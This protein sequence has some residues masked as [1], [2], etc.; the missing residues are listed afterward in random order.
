MELIKECFEKHNNAFTKSLINANFSLDEAMKFLPE[1]ISSILES[2]NKTSVYQ[3]MKILMSNRPN[4]LL[5]KINVPII[6]RK[7]EMTQFQV[8]TGLQAIAPILLQT[9]SEAAYH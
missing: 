5:R 8:T 2:S 9:Y 6:A 3:T 7:S 1:A 4:L